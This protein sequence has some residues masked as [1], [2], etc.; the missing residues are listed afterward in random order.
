MQE[1]SSHDRRLAKTATPGIYKRGT[2]Y[3][4]AFRDPEGRQR[5]R[6]ARTL[7]EARDLKAMVMA[8]VTRGEYRALSRITFADYAVDWIDTYAGR[9]SR[10]IR[11]T[12]LRDYRTRL[13]LDDE[14]AS[15]GRGAVAFFGRMRLSEIQPQH[16]RKFVAHTASRGIA[17]NTVRLELA[18][19]KALFATALEDGVIRSNPC[20]GVR[21]ATAEQY[22]KD[23]VPSVKA[24]R[25]DEYAAV[26]AALPEEW[27]L[28]F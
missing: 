8:D 1:A 18:P 4:V 26:I 5:K 9:T 20:A 22:D 16:V 7:A 6:S 21:I 25:P 19:V 23:G 28:P 13:G 24:P 10:G 3:V 17:A 15:T 12:T 14:G 11:P 27:K 2:R